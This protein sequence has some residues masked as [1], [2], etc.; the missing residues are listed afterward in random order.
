[1]IALLAAGGAA[2]WMVR[3]SQASARP[4]HH[5]P[6]Y[7]VAHH[8]RSVKATPQNP[9]GHP[10]M[11]Y[12]DTLPDSH[13]MVVLRLQQLLAHAGYLPVKFHPVGTQPMYTLAPRRGIFRWPFDPPS[14]LREQFEPRVYGVAT[15]AAVMSFES[16]NGMT[17]DGIASPRVWKK[18]LSKK[19]HHAP[20]PYTYV[21]VRESLPETITI[22]QKSHAVYEAP[23]NT[24][25][26]QAPTALGTYPVYERFTSTT[27]QGTNP[28]GSHYNDPGVP[29]VS[30][31]N[32]GDAVHGF[33]RASYGSPQSLG[34]VELSFGD[35]AQAYKL[36][37]YGTLVTVAAS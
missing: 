25:I 17:P 24:G 6:W 2:A 33:P 26:A 8:Y 35:A 32:G 1:V 4:V 36:M 27:M 34:C 31:F 3:D 11:V 20:R 30:Y 28:D 14:G 37:T 12:P 9:F 18:L 10:R 16:D 15:K 23:A 19:P 21:L 7:P 5:H 13:G 29:W 22:Y